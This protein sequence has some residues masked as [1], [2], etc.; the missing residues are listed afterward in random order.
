MRI[1]KS[2]IK[3]INEEAP[4]NKL[5]LSENYNNFNYQI[6]NIKIHLYNKL[7]KIKKYLFIIS[8]KLHF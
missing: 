5:L 7:F 8:S 2:N 6:V 4:L 1:M 3:T